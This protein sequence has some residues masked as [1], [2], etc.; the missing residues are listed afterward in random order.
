MT[1]PSTILMTGFTPFGGETTNPSWQAVQR[2]ASL[3]NGPERLVIAEIPTVFGLSGQT[4]RALMHEHQPDLVI[5]VGQAGGRAQITP[6]RIAINVDD[7]RIP[8]N[9]GNQPIDTTIAAEGP[10]AHF[11]TLPIKQAV[12]AMRAQGIPAA[13]SNSAGTFVCNHLFY[14]LMQLIATEF[15][16]A[17]GGFV[18]VP[19]SPDQV[20]DTPQPSLSIELIAQGLVT[21]ARTAIDVRE[22]VALVGGAEH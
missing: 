20:T 13:V 9:D 16:R 1:L 5:A 17:R 18:H 14:S 2:A 6:E 21:I 15:P 22:D 10:A 7:A 3:W 19:F 8:D 12:A 4:L 11:T